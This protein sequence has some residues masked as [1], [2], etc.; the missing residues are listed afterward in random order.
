MDHDYEPAGRA[1]L[2]SFSQHSQMSSATS[3]EST[4][5]LIRVQSDAPFMFVSGI[6]DLVGHFSEDVLPRKYAQNTMGAHNA[7]IVIAWMLPRIDSA[8]AQ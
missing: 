4:H 2:E 1:I 8:L 7:G 3:L 6:V 5:G